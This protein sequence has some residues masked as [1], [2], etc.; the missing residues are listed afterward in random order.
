VVPPPSEHLSKDQEDSLPK[1]SS[2]F[3]VGQLLPCVVKGT[4]TNKKGKKTV[5]LSLCP[6]VL[7]QR[8]SL[9]NISNGMVRIVDTVKECLYKTV[10]LSS[11]V[12]HKSLFMVALRVWRIMA[13]LFLSVPLSS[14]ASWQ[15][16][17]W[18]MK[19][20]Q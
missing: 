2:F 18:R 14:P 3:K 19:K 8:L 16:P 12:Y 5:L 7:N 20:V 4:E 17:P 1:L 11:F 6:S 9:A 10:L 15:R 13:T